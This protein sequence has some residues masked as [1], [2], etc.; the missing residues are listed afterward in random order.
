MFWH[1]VK[2]C[3]EMM[4]LHIAVFVGVEEDIDNLIGI[5]LEF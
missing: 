4:Q 2:S 5:G 3:I 1:P